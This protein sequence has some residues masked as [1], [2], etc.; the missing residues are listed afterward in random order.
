MC[1]M[2]FGIENDPPPLWNFSENSLVLVPPPVPKFTYAFGN[3]ISSFDS[4]YNLL[5]AQTPDSCQKLSRNILFCTPCHTKSLFTLNVCCVLLLLLHRCS[6][7]WSSF[8]HISYTCVTI[9]LALRSPPF[10]VLHIGVLAGLFSSLY[11]L[12]FKTMYNL[13]SSVRV[14]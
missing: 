10:L 1:N 14:H 11:N 3:V 12:L 9:Y 7:M 5:I 6:T 13:R 2:I 4:I 8:V